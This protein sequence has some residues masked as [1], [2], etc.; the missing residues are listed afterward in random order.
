MEG[1]RGA[2]AVLST[3]LP[4]PG[5]ASGMFRSPHRSYLASKEEEN[6]ADPT[7]QFADSRNDISCC[8]L[9]FISFFRS[10]IVFPV[11]CRFC[12]PFA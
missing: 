1:R 6:G 5:S 9:L 8:C 4:H 12:H 2:E 10:L 11:N 3:G 7:F